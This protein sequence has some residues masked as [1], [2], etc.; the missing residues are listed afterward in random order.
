M[1]L[2]AEL[3]FSVTPFNKPPL[4]PQYFPRAGDWIVQNATIKSEVIRI[5][6]YCYIYTN[7]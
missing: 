4:C 3:L 1:A 7:R 2:G 6:V 5:H